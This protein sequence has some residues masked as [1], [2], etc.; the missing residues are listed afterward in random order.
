MLQMVVHRLFGPQGTQ[1][2]TTEFG[3]DCH[4]DERRQ[5]HRDEY[6]SVISTSVSEEKS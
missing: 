1:L 3:T 5:C 6:R 4:F 2:G